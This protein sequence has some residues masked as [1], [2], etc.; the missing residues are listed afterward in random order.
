MVGMVVYCL[1]VYG[2]VVGLLA[3]M[4]A[5]KLVSPRHSRKRKVVLTLLLKNAAGWVEEIVGVVLSW[6]ERWGIP[7]QVIAVDRGS[8]D[9]TPRILERIARDRQWITVT[10]IA[11]LGDVRLDEAACPLVLC[12]LSACTGEPDSLLSL[13]DLLNWLLVDHLV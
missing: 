11:R 8:R 3:I 1:A 2:L 4:E 5:A 12:D 9:D 6:S 7:L 10:D 13:G